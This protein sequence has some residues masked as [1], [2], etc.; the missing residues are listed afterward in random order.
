MESIKQLA[1]VLFFNK[2][3]GFAEL[4]SDRSSIFLHH[5]DIIGKK[6]LHE[7]D[8]VACFVVPNNHPKHPFKATEIELVEPVEVVSTAVQL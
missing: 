8:V 3:Y 7:G 4:R 2:G 1:V 6:I 5:S